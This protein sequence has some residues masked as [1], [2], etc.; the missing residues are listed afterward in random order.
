MDP[1]KEYS[2]QHYLAN[3]HKRKVNPEKKAAIE[4]RGNI[5]CTRCRRTLPISQ[6]NT[7][8]NRASGYRSHCKE[9]ATDTHLRK[10]YGITSLEKD[11]ML[12]AQ[13]G[14]C[15]IC[16]TADPGVSSWHTDHCHTTGS[17]R[18]ILCTNCNR[19]LG[20]FQDSIENLQAAISYLKL[21]PVGPSHTQRKR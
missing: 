6:F 4:S 13:G 3:K 17:V 10:K 18:G 5:V 9:C 14:N 20:H 12:R 1:M 19:G 21:P 15:A 11:A 8:N 7:D 16:G 2:R